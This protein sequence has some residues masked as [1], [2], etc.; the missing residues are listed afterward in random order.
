M[1]KRDCWSG[2][3]SPAAA[4]WSV[5]I[6]FPRYDQ[7][8]PSEHPR[9]GRPQKQQL[10]EPGEFAAASELCRLSLSSLITCKNRD[11]VT[12]SYSAPVY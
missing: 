2:A 8:F 10:I 1:F 9:F 5:P 12:R 6:V 11:I 3:P 7:L 4:P